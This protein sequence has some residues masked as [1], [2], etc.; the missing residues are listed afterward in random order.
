MLKFRNAF[1]MLELIFV[2]IIIGIL[3]KFGVEF[4]AQAYKNF[5]FSSINNTLQSQSATTVEFISSR[6][7]HRIKDSIIARNSDD[8]FNGLSGYSG[9]S[10]KIL[11]W[12]GTDMDGFRGYSLP[13]WSGVIDLDDGNST[14][15]VSPETNTSAID[16]LIGVLSNGNSGVNDAALYFVGSNTDVTTGYGWDSNLSQIDIQ[17]GAMHPIRKNNTNE[18]EFIPINSS[19][20]ADNNFTGI[21]V[22]EYYKLAWSAYAVVHDSSD[23]NLTL[24]YDYQ[25]WKGESYSVG[26]SST[27]M[28]NVSSFRFM[29]VGS[30][31]KIQ[32][33][34]KS[35]LTD[36]EYSICKEKTIY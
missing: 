31:V 11:E 16:T 33:C 1:T 20:G 35:T 36:K 13:Y 29:A 2:I 12:V 8:S 25:P 14:T 5:I 27:I 26:K 22:Y 28:E 32:V 4:V 6:L 30:V 21:N 18:N 7:Q 23:G 9:G 19:S 34:V 24:Y 15:L 3:S 10:A 17:Q